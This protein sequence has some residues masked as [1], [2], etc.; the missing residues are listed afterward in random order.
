[1]KASNSSTDSGRSSTGAALEAGAGAGMEAAGD[2]VVW[3]AVWGF[4]VVEEA[5]SSSRDVAASSLGRK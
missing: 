5:I 3:D 2:E 4:S 1:M